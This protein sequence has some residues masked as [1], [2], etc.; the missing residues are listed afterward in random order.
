MYR[1]LDCGEVFDEADEMYTTYEAYYGV[2][3]DFPD[4][5]PLTLEVCPRCKSDE[6]DEVDDVYEDEEEE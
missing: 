2:A 6:I 3:S 5:T 4:R 1:C